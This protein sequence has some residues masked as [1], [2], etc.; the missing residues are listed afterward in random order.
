MSDVRTETNIDKNK[1][2]IYMKLTE[3][4]GSLF[5]KRKDTEVFVA[6]AAIGF[7]YKKRKPI[8]GT[9]HSL[10]P[11]SMYRSDDPNLWM[12]KSI[13]IAAGGIDVLKDLRQVAAIVEEYANAGVDILYEKH[14][15]NS[16]D[17]IYSMAAELIEIM[18]V[19]GIQ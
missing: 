16:D 8:T 12:L 5:Y 18:E 4:E 15:N 13:A 2:D 17:E 10:Y 9:K 19:E 7:Y 11:M 1:R 3:D 14:Q 6:S